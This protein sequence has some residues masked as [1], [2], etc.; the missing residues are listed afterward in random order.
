MFWD[1]VLGGCPCEVKLTKYPVQS[2]VVI[3][4]KSNHL[5]C[6]MVLKILIL[7]FDIIKMRQL[8]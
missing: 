6:A 5:T 4:K 1:Q 8:Q 7:I 3:C 2:K